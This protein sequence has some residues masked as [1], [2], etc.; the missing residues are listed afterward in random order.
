ML[1]KK[2]KKKRKKKKELLDSFCLTGVVVVSRSVMSDSVQPYGLQSAKVPLSMG[3]S[4]QEYWSGMSS[5]SPGDLPHPGIEP[6]SSDH[7]QIL[8]HLRHQGN[9]ILV[10]ALP[11]LNLMSILRIPRVLFCAH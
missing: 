8:Y 10:G 3:F 9:P 11:Y 2:K 7:R 1:C 6:G 5:P 4:R